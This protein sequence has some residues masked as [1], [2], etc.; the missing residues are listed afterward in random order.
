MSAASDPQAA[1]RTAA[2]ISGSPVA[3]GAQPQSDLRHLADGAAWAILAAVAAL[4][5]LT[6]R[7]Y[8]LGWDDF[9]HAQMGEKLLALY[10]SGFHDTAALSFVNLYMYGGG[11]DM[12]AALAHRVLPFD[13]FE[14]RR[15]VGGLVGLAGL[16][17]TWRIGRRLA[18]PVAGLVALALLATC[19][20]F[21][22]HMFINSKDAPFAVAMALLMLGVLRAF[23]EYPRP[24]A[25]TVVLLGL[26]IGFTIGTRI[27]GGIAVIYAVLPLAILIIAD[28][29]LSG[30]RAAL[31]QGLQFFLRLLPA[32]VLGYALMGLLWPWAVTSP[33]NPLRALTYFSVFFEKPWRELF[34]GE[35]F[36]VPD[37]PASYLPTML[38]L[39]LPEVMTALVLLGI[40]LSTWCLLLGRGSVRQRAGLALILAA[41]LVPVA[42]GIVTRPAMY[43]GFRHFLFVLPPL[44]VIGG[45]A[46]AS[47]I[48]R[49]RH[50]GRPAIAGVAALLAAGLV[51]PVVEMVRLHPYQYTHFNRI[52]GGVGSA[53]SRFMV[54]YW[55]LSFKEAA[56][57]L[58]ARLAAASEVP[59]PGRAW[60]IAV[61][62]PHPPAE[63]ALGEDFDVTWDPDGADFALM[64]GAYY[65]RQFTA[66]VLAR[67]ERD[68]FAYATAYD[69]RQRSFSTL[70]T[71]PPP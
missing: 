25:A 40:V 45:L 27:L 29:R 63:V 62:G 67:I 24:R 22:G 66:P 7:D 15:L 31:G 8:G 32:A 1:S 69:I 39:K 57:G 53:S 60:K 18:G 33:L 34:A 41:G 5:L 37:M 2:S 71:A 49:A 19:P 50:A 47:L 16:A 52:A 11:F 48:D 17:V 30:W 58:R 23:D 35:L 20:A 6:F 28:A 43:N 59:P 54:D 38:G 36:L 3:N 42:I 68:G 21:Y 4:V 13:L 12:A 9:T 61:C 65:C 26:G 55:G 56:A 51:S 10:A 70:F 14:T 46:G 64:L 44:A